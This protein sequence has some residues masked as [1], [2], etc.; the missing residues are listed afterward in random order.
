MRKYFENY[1]YWIWQKRGLWAYVTY[2][3]MRIFRALVALRRFLYAHQ[4]LKTIRLPVPVI[5]VGNIYVGGVGK[6]PFV[7]SLI[8]LLQKAGFKPG[9]I[10]RGYQRIRSDQSLPQL[11]NA[12]TDIELS[13]DEA[14][15]IAQKTGVPVCV[16][17]DRVL[18]GQYLVQQHKAVDIIISD[19][20]LQHYRLGR[21]LEIIVSDSR[22]I[23]NGFM[24]PAGPLREPA[25]RSADIFVAHYGA[26]DNLPPEKTFEMFMLPGFPYQLINPKRKKMLQ[27]LFGK[28][29]LMAAGIANPYRFFAMLFLAGIRGEKMALPDHYPFLD[30]P[31]V[32]TQAEIILVTEKDAV[33]CRANPEL[34]NDERI[35]VVPLLPQMYDTERLL[36]T[37]LEKLNATRTTGHS[38]MSTL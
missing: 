34:K 20:G 32:K 29:T 5:V 26:R 19:D 12:D 13:G 16:H 6:T 36:Q 30:N 33:K 37:I 38:R 15:L 8:E 35:W 24:L 11:V 22:G 31:F 7:M 1:L 21:D 28:K 2:P 17:K 14:L 3:L 25:N 10:L 9:V 4:F 27:D 18:A 23:G